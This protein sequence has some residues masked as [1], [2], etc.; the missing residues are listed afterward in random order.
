M[1]TKIALRNL[2][3]NRSKTL[4]VGGL[5]ALGVTLLVMGN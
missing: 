1:I 4:I 5:I 3:E 2:T